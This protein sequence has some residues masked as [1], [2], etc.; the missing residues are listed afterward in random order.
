MYHS[1]LIERSL[2][3][4]EILA[5]ELLKYKRNVLYANSEEMI[6]TCLKNDNIHLII[7]G[8]GLPK[9][10]TLSM[11][12]FIDNKYPSIEKHI[13]EKIPGI[14]PASMID[15]TNEKAVM[16]RLMNARK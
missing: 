12:S 3:T 8:A 10:T 4:L 13:M 2:S 15:Y 7:V 16:W 5:D 11:V 14:T 6:D 1:L 9:E